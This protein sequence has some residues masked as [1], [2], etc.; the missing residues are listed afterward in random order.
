MKKT[1]SR[2]DY[3]NPYGRSQK[4]PNTKFQK[5]NITVRTHFL[6]PWVTGIEFFV[7]RVTEATKLSCVACI[8]LSL[9]I[10]NKGRKNTITYGHRIHSKSLF[11]YLKCRFTSFY[12]I[13][14]GY[15]QGCSTYCN[16]SG[17]RQIFLRSCFLTERD[18]FPI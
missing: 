12:D 11:L 5:Q 13:L 14:D 8:R 3:P 18:K 15:G 2:S 16:F 17:C 6:Q 10:F 1:A 7:K 9:D 4:L